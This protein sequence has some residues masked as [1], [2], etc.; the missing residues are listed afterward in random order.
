MSANKG[1]CISFEGGEGTSKK[2]QISLLSHLLE[3]QGIDN[4]VTRESG[5]SSLGEMIRKVL[6]EPELPELTALR[7][8]C[9]AAA[10]L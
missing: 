6:L 7:A 4:I 9:I 3:Y 2:T 5:G 10:S 1:V 8:F